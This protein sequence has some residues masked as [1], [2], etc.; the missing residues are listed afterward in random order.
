[1]V[2]SKVYIKAQEFVGNPK[3][4]DFKIIEQEVDDNLKDQGIPTLNN[5]FGRF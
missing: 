5:M 3:D 1:M 4:E 2:K